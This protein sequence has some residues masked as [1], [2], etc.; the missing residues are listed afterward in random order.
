MDVFHNPW[1]PIIPDK[2]HRFYFRWDGNRPE[3]FKQRGDM[4]YL[5]DVQNLSGCF[6]GQDDDL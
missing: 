3:Y 4:L 2:L 6:W 5:R 1:G